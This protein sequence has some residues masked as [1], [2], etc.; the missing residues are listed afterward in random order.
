M[1]MMDAGQSASTRR[2]TYSSNDE[3]HHDDARRLID[4]D[5]LELLIQFLQ[6]PN[7]LYICRGWVWALI[8]VG[9]WD[10]C[11]FVKGGVR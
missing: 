5:G 8:E 10:G 2:V 11:V 1:W 6:I 4:I 9:G 3:T 7:L